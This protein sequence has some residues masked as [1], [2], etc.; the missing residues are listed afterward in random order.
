MWITVEQL[1][2]LLDTPA[3]IPVQGT[4]PKLIV[5]EQILV[6]GLVNCRHLVPQTHETPSHERVLARGEISEEAHQRLALLVAEET[7]VGQFAQLPDVAEHFSGIGH[8]LVNVVKVGQDNLSPVPEAVQRLAFDGLGSLLAKDTLAH[9][10][11]INMVEA[12]DGI[13]RV[14]YDMLAQGEEQVAKRGIS[15][16]P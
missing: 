8:V 3:D 10:R 11:Y 2:L 12:A 6:Q 4:L 16:C 13:Y 7:V 1:R 15:R 5:V 9:A 14:G